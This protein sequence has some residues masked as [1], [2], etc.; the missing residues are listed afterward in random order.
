VPGLQVCLDDV[1][2]TLTLGLITVL[3]VHSP[4]HKVKKRI[5]RR[6]FLRRDINKKHL[7]GGGLHSRAAI[8]VQRQPHVAP[9]IEVLGIDPGLV[10]GDDYATSVSLLEQDCVTYLTLLGPGERTARRLP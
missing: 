3:A 8:V 5:E 2:K 4:T 1:Q 9:E 10:M 6:L 7:V